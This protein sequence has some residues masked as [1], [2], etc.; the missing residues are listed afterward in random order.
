MI[1]LPHSS[2]KPCY[3]FNMAHRF[4]FSVLLLIFGIFIPFFSYAA[5]LY[6]SIGRST[7]SA[8]DSFTAAILVSSS[9]QAMNAASGVISFPSDKLAATAVSK[10]NSILTLWVQDPSYSNQNGTVNFSGVVPNPGWA[11]L[12]G[13]IM[14]IQFRAL[15]AGAAS[16]EFSSSAVLA[17]DGNG[18]NILTA[19][20]P[21][22]VTVTEA[23]TAPPP[24]ASTPAQAT[25]SKLS[26]VRIT[27]S[28]H[29]DQEKTYGE[30]HAVLDW[31]N[32][33][34]TPTVRIGYNKYPNTPGTVVYSPAISH[35]EIDLED[36]TW[37]FHVQEKDGDTWGP[38]A[39]YVIRVDTSLP[40]SASAEDVAT[41][42][43]VVVAPLEE[44]S[45]M[46][47]AYLPLAYA[48]PIVAVVLALLIIGWELAR[49]FATPRGTARRVHAAIHVEFNELKD[50]IA[51]E[52]RKLEKVRV[53]RELT[54]E[55]ERLINRL[56]KL[57]DRSE[58]AVENIIDETP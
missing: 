41:T 4:A 5:T 52:I 55:E 9:D 14:T 44:P 19:A 27:S 43:P 26:P 13:Q 47:S 17:N 36:G 3:D 58:R 1:T 56:G 7:V 11:G 50:S 25:S 18:T 40:L 35:K 42:T 38:V 32:H 21:S 23:Q 20:A 24:P 46:R 45:T 37:Y 28:T 2:K 54:A 39:T 29:P 34:G 6:V 31:T 16:I 30:T 48:I 57:I 15:K 33:A 22:T 10:L 8:G 12:R 53:K 51:D 49:S